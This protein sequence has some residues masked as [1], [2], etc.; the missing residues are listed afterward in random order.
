MI[1]RRQAAFSFHLTELEYHRVQ[2]MADHLELLFLP[3]AQL[4]RRGQ[5]QR[6]NSLMLRMSYLMERTFEVIESLYQPLQL[7]SHLE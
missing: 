3:I 2:L 4:F 6:L 1:L 7:Y 5:H